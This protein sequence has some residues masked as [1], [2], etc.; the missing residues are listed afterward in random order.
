MATHNMRPKKVAVVIPCHNAAARI[1]QVI[2]KLSCSELEQNGLQ[3]RAYVVDNN[4]SDHTAAV[5][6]KAGAVVVREPKPGKGNALRAGFQRLPQDVDYVVMLDGNGA[7]NPEEMARLIEPLQSDFCDVTIGSRLSRRTQ[8]AAMRRFNRTGNRLFTTAVRMLY[9][10]NV[11]DAPGEYFAWK[12]SAL[13]KLRPHITSAGSAIEMEMVTKMARLHYQMASV[14]ISYRPH[15]SSPKPHPFRG[16][17][18]VFWALLKNLTWQPTKASIAATKN[19]STSKPRKIVFVSDAIYPYMKGGKEKRLHEITKRLAVMGHDV[20]ICTMHWWNEPGESR[21]EAGVHLDAICKYHPM[22]RGD[23]RTISEG[24]I[25]GLACFKLLRVRFDILDVDHMPFFPVLSAWF[26]CT[27]RR[28]KL[29]ATWHEALSRQEWVNYMGRSGEIA[30]LIERLCI[31]L[32]Y[33]ITAASAHT[34]ELLATIHGRAH[35]VALVPSGIDTLLL[36]KVQSAPINCDVLYVGRL[37]KDKNVDKLID[38]VSLITHTK[39]AVQCVV[40]GDGVEKPRL[41]A[42]VSRQNLQANVTFLEPLPKAADVYAY[43]KAAKVFCSPSMREGFGIVSLEALGCGTPVITIDSPTNAARHLVQDGENGSIVSLK[44]AALADAI[45]HWVSLAQ[46]PDT[47]AWVAGHDWR[48]L[49]LKQA[50]VY[51]A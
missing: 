35:R 34:K 51:S 32:P 47:S 41:Q 12:K 6:K 1:A 42:Q 7:Y 40:I 25:F 44:P 8:T 50:E 31:R 26:V 24:I 27:V 10:A 19:K 48:Q 28:R 15:A 39:P 46:K 22:Y 45:S 5:A 4:S 3:I 43:M 14:P 29:Y 2:A 36:R 21:L 38:A 11:S 16:G 23:R 37:V 49:A 18:A 20:H 17:F 33:C 9:H 30:S 13:D